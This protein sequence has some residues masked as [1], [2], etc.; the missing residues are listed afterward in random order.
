MQSIYVGNSIIPPE[1]EQV[2]NF[3][4]A[5]EKPNSF[6]LLILFISCRKKLSKQSL[7]K[8][9][10]LVIITIPTSHS[11]P[12]LKKKKKKKTV[13]KQTLKAKHACCGAN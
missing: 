4:S 13:P 10:N 2:R 5:M 7:R 8:F 12:K 3:I 11:N 6:Y 1:T 9:N